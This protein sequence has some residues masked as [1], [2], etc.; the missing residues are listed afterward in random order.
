MTEHELELYKKAKKLERGE[1][2]KVGKDDDN[3]EEEEKVI[4]K[5]IEDDEDDLDF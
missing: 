1:T 5:T 2:I 4:V 3:D